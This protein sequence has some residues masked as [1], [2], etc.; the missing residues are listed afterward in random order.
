[1]NRLAPARAIATAV[2]LA[3][4][5]PVALPAWAQ[6]QE[7]PPRPAPLGP[8]RDP[9]L[10]NPGLRAEVLRAAGQVDPAMQDA[11]FQG[12]ARDPALRNP[13]P[14]V[15]A[16]PAPVLQDNA[17][18]PAVLQA[19]YDAER[20]DLRLSWDQPVSLQIDQPEG[21]IVIRSALPFDGTVL[22]NI[23]GSL[24]PWVSSVSWGYDSLVLELAEGAGARVERRPDEVAIAF[25][26]DAADRAVAPV[27][28]QLP[29][30]DRVI[31]AAAPLPQAVE[32]DAEI[33]R[34]LLLTR[35]DLLDGEPGAAEERAFAVLQ[36][37][38]DRRDVLEATADAAAQADDWRQAGQLYDRLRALSPDNTGF[39]RA[40]RE[41]RRLWGNR[42]TL[43]GFVQDVQD[44]DSQRGLEAVLRVQPLP[45]WTLTA[46]TR[47]RHMQI[48]NVLRPD[49]QIL[50]Y[51][52]SRADGELGASYRLSTDWTFGGRFLINPVGVGAAAR[53]QY[54]PPNRR[55]T[56]DGEWNAPVYEFTETIA[57]AGTRDRAALAYRR[58]VG[59]DVTVLASAHYNNYALPDDPD[60]AQTAGFGAELDYVLFQALFR[61][62]PALVATY[63]FDG[64]WVLQSEERVSALGQTYNPLPINSREANTLSLGLFGWLSQDTDYALQLGYTYDRIQ[65]QS[66]E[67]AAQLRWQPTDAF[68]I[69]GD[70]SYGLS[71]GRG[72][73]ASVLRAGLGI[74]VN[75]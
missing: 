5:A 70:A 41:A 3:V 30:Q 28:A 51:D 10:Q 68:E 53:I 22:G 56:L 57:D 75:F 4:L 59:Q 55:L 61:D 74:A 42:F 9:L 29:D 39:I 46:R 48:D 20:Q 66:P 18:Q 26:P 12:P 35:A 16:P 50:P 54:G 32:S 60:V 34:Q 2:L 63:R 45:D 21:E 47:Q 8:S 33:R 19:R 43:S 14:L 23:S 71:T 67:G 40:S 1:M 6:P 58:L 17:G 72:N 65:G 38:P 24:A 62:G 36:R 44:A 31:L 37:H 52:G 27:A 15:A 7:P 13:A 49:G 25:G 69:F 11:A 73:D 64:D